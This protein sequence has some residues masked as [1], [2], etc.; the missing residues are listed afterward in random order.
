MKATLT[1]L[2]LMAGTALAASRTS[3]PEGCITVSQS[4]S[5][6]HSTVQAAVDSLDESAT[7]VQCIFIESGTYEEQVLVSERAASQFNIYGYTEDD[8]S[9]AGNTVT[10]VYNLSQNDGLNNDE[11]GTLR[12]KTPN[13][14]LYNVNVENS[15]GEGSQA[16]ALSAYSDS[17]FYGSLF[18]GYQDTVLANEGYQ[19]YLDTQIIGA[20]DFIFGQRAIAWFERCDIKCVEKSIGYVTAH[21]RDEDNDSYYAFDYCTVSG[22]GDNVPDGAYF[23][24]RPWRDH[25]RVVFQRTEMS[26]VINDAGWKVWSEGDDTSNIYYGEFENTGPGAEGE[27]VDWAVAMDAPIAIGD[28]LGSYES[29]GWFDASYYAGSGADVGDS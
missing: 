15:Y 27:R 26:E 20:T 17:G 8:T 14:R 22:E 29:A 2:S 16:V 23:L 6:D 24:G 25:A 9:F 5:G 3:A 19:V 18:R 12:V 21:G 4:G 7:D 11:T 13:F 28:L 1:S 10:I